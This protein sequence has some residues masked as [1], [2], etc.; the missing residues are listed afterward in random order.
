MV[1]ESL[2]DACLEAVAQAVQTLQSAD[3]MAPIAVIV[4]SSA[5]GYKVR[6]SLAERNRSVINVRTYSLD[7]LALFMAAPALSQDG[8]SHYTGAKRREATY[9]AIKG[10]G[11]QLGAIADHPDTPAAILAI[12]DAAEGAQSHMPSELQAVQE[13]F[14]RLLP[15]AASSQMVREAAARRIEASGMGSFGTPILYLP[16]ELEASQ[17]RLVQAICGVPEATVIV[18]ATQDARTDERLFDALEPLGVDAAMPA[19]QPS[20][21]VRVISGLDD[22]DEAE[23]AATLISDLL[24]TGVPR[25]SIGVLV[26]GA[27]SAAQIERHLQSVGVHPLATSH[28]DLA[29]SPWW[30][31]VRAVHAA[32]RSGYRAQAQ[33]QVICAISDLCNGGADLRRVNLRNLRR[34]GVKF[35]WGWISSIRD[36]AERRQAEAIRTICQALELPPTAHYKQ[37]IGQVRK[38]LVQAATSLDLTASAA[39]ASD[40]IAKILD[41]LTGTSVGDLKTSVERFLTESEIALRSASRPNPFQDRVYV[42][43]LRQGAAIGFQHLFILGGV[44]SALPAA[45]DQETS[46]RRMLGLPPLETVEKDRAALYTAIASAQS[47]TIGWHR[48]RSETRQDSAPS[49]FLIELLT[50]IEGQ[51][52][53]PHHLESGLDAPW[54]IRHPSYSSKIKSGFG[55]TP[56][57]KVA[58][59][60]ASPDAAHQARG[61][62]ARPEA[63]AAK[64]FLHAQRSTRAGWIDPGLAKARVTSG[65]FSPTRIDSYLQLSLI[66]I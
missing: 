60:L 45:R 7:H 10:T 62:A 18:G 25:R 41:S 17:M 8:Y 14:K 4:G 16:Q 50:E 51:Q 24:S 19:V 64:E 2:G 49:R 12:F 21:E 65:V 32:H 6:E 5:V 63:N 28:A 36:E 56:E 11:N 15:K 23:T 39:E 47:V 48:T 61:R 29:A 42:G 34:K 38:G 20:R 44:D 31:L 3:P 35:G 66:H 22:D 54:H 59:L 26:C 43:N 30:I 37:F 58:A 27:G 52:L 53:M 33:E 9:Q 46:T 55:P 13:E 57:S 40:R 1:V